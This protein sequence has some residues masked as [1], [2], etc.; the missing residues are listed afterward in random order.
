MKE[1]VEKSYRTLLK[2]YEEIP[3]ASVCFNITGCTIEG[4]AE[5]FPDVL[6]G[7]REGCARGQFE[8]LSSASYH[9]IL[10]L[11]PYEHAVDQIKHNV[12]LIRRHVGFE[13]KGFFPPEHGYAA[14][15]IDALKEAG[16]E[17]FILDELVVKRSHPDLG[18]LYKP[19]WAIG[20]REKAIC[21]VRAKPIS[22][23]LWAASVGGFSTDDF[24][25]FCEQFPD[26]FLLV[27]S[28]DAELIGLHWAYGPTWL[29]ECLQKLLKSEKIE[30]VRVSDWLRDHPPSR[31]LFLNAGT[32]AHDGKFTLW[33]ERPDN[34]S[35]HRLCSFARLK[36]VTAEY[37]VRLAEAL[38]I[39]TSEVKPLLKEAKKTIYLAEMSDGYGWD[40]VPLRK[41]F[42]YSS[43]I[44]AE[45]LADE[46]IELVVCKVRRR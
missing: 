9:P 35:L 26:D 30:L 21:V 20:A 46:I 6:E 2:L 37:F 13:P 8:I 28:T 1:S 31:T 22:Q 23:G 17:W 16:L 11:I 38:G 45:E 41:S 19:F 29:R 3:E 18:E 24:L 7:L 10:P 43:I 32:W 4:L 36:V 15:I 40:P 14:P 27:S 34:V 39:D 33:T 12:E 44:K 42:A 25:R 5:N